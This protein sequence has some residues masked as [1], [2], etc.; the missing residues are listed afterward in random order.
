MVAWIDASKFRGF[1][2][3]IIK[4]SV[5]FCCNHHG[6]FNSQRQDKLKQQIRWACMIHCQQFLRHTC[7]CLYDFHAAWSVNRLSVPAQS[8]HLH[9]FA[10]EACSP[11][12]FSITAYKCIFYYNAI[13]VILFF[14]L[15]FQRFFLSFY[16]YHRVGTVLASLIFLRFYTNEFDIMITAIL[17]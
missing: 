4:R 14:S 5:D 15:I 3:L 16:L 11:L 1:A 6:C 10:D 17:L 7:V 13:L 8:L 9:Q 12:S 2:E